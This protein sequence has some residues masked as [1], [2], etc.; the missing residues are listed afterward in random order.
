GLRHPAQRTRERDGQAMSRPARRRGCGRARARRARRPA[1]VRRLA[2]HAGSAERNPVDH[3]LPWFRACA[4]ALDFA[5]NE[6]TLARDGGDRRVG[7]MQPRS[8]DLG[9]DVHRRARSPVPARPLTTPTENPKMLQFLTVA[10]VAVLSAGVG[11]KQAAVDTSSYK[12]D[13]E[14]WRQ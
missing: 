4:S 8:A 11:L 12:A 2:A 3:G 14:K 9:A 6:R 1:R 7:P 10:A 13:I 5:G